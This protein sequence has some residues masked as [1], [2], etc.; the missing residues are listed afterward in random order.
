MIDL[1]S[2]LHFDGVAILDTVPSRK[3]ALRKV[4]ELLAIHADVMQ[5]REVFFALEEREH[6]ASTV[7]DD[8][9]VAIPHCRLPS[10]EESKVVL[11]KTREEKGID[12][13]DLSVKLVVGF[14]FPENANEE[15]L[16]ILRSVVSVIG[17]SE[18]LDS[19]LMAQTNEALYQI[20]TDGLNTVTT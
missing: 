16:Q 5:S 10:C 12:F 15:A 1:T 11:L 6:Q 2:V 20:F 9:P 19:L 8:L 18:R 7:L 14:C 3:T 17:D 4:A 13:G